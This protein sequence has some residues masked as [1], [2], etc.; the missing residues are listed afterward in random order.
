MTTM[1]EWPR[2][3]SWRTFDACVRPSDLAADDLLDECVRAP[4]WGSDAEGDAGRHDM[5]RGEGCVMAVGDR[6]GDAERSAAW[7]AATG[8]MTRWRL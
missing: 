8:T 1:S 2:A 6:A 5:D 3:G 4:A 7:A